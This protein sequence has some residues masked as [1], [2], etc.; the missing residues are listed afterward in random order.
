MKKHYAGDRRSRCRFNLDL[1]VSYRV[2]SWHQ[3]CD[4][5]S[6]KTIDI[7][8]KGV[9]FT[10]ERALKAGTMLELS[11]S[12]PVLLDKTCLLQLVATGPVVRSNDAVTAI[13]I[14]RHE[15]RTQSARA[16]VPAQLEKALSHYRPRRMPSR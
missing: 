10:S 13:G 6:G 9:A 3:V 7:S 11:V 12:W 15:F 5:G 2:I 16:L 8:S 1:K 14:E 4:A